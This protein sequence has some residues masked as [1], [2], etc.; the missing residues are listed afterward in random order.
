VIRLDGQLERLDLRAR[1]DSDTTLVV[2]GPDG[3]RHCN[4]DTYSLDPS[5]SLT[6]AMAG[7]YAVWVGTYGEEQGVTATLTA[8][9]VPSVNA[10]DVAG[11]PAAGRHAI[12]SGGTLD[13]AL[14]LAPTTP[15]VDIAPEC[16]GQ[17]DPSRPDA[18]VSLDGGAGQLEISATSAT[19]T[20]LVVVTPEG[21]RLCNDDSSGLDP[22]VTVLPAGAGDYAIWVGTY[23]EQAG[24]EASLRVVAGAAPEL[25]PSGDVHVFGG[26]D[27]SL[28]LALTPSISASDFGPDCWG[29]VRAE[30]PDAVIRLESGLDLVQISATGPVDTTLLVEAPDGTVHCN[31][32]TF[33]LDPAV[34]LSPAAAGDYSV[35]VGTF[36]GDAATVTLRV[37]DTA[38]AGSDSAG[39]GGEFSGAT[40]SPFFGR[41]LPDA[42]AAFELLRD[43]QG[44]G[45]FLTYDRIEPQGAEGFVLHGVTIT[46]PSGESPPLD[47]A[48]LR[49]S[50]LDL[51]GLSATGAPGRF[52]IA[53]EGI[54]YATLAAAVNEE[55]AAGGMPSLPEL[56]GN[57][58]LSSTVS[59]LPASDDPGRRIMSADITLDGQFALAFEARMRWPEGMVGIGPE[60]VDAPTESMVVE[61]RNYGFLGMLVE[62][63]ASAAGMEPAAFNQLMIDSTRALIAPI[64][65]GSS[66]EQLIDA[67]SAASAAG[68]DQPGVLR[69]RLASDAPRGLEE[70]FEGLESG[71]PLGM[72]EDSV[73]VT[74]EP[75][76]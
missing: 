3:T 35:R 22:A 12:S 54:D 69:V 31:D 68:L 63:Q 59:L 53:L 30:G 29:Q 45:Q 16:W 38:G 40:E 47:A 10:L 9:T 19:D 13:L 36:G 62:A 50:D 14:S 49:V 28:S 61:L 58:E 60:V 8:S 26:G 65:P 76:P 32:D 44:I 39:L 41:D 11:E 70:L 72:L 24:A 71:N 25:M 18:V 6:P 20:T 52:V 4:D 34:T 27:L 15:V 1:S 21:A 48:R 43:E 51:E 7:S 2:V 5:V 55:A 37:G 75:L 46:D 56:A 67:L 74:F 57:P 66:R 17:I 33:G 64:T 23:D 73:E 42:V